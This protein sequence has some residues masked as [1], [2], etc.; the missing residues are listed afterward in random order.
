MIESVMSK[1]YDH[2]T[3]YWKT[4]SIIDWHLLK[5]LYKKVFYSKYVYG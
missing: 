5:T 4:I 3:T 2:A 1:I